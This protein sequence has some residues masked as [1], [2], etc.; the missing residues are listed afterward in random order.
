MF[1]KSLKMVIVTSSS[2]L[3]SYLMWHHTFKYQSKFI[4]TLKKLQKLQKM[5]E[6][7][8]PPHVINISFV[9]FVSV[10]ISLICLHAYNYDVTETKLIAHIFTF[11]LLDSNNIHRS[12]ALFA[13]HIYNFTWQ[14]Y[15]LFTCYFAL[16]YVIICLCMTT[17]LQKHATV[18]SFILK[19]RLT[20]LTS[21]NA[22]DDCFARY[23][24]IL[25]TFDNINSLLSFT[26]F[27]QC[28]FNISGMFWVTYRIRKG[29]C[30]ISFMDILLLII[31][32]ILF[33]ATV[34]SASNVHEAD[35]K[36][37]KSNFNVLRLLGDINMKQNIEI[38]SHVCHFPPFTLTGWN[39]FE[40]T[41]SFYLTALGCFV[42]YSLL[43][44]NL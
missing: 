11:T 4:K 28:C 30:K 20:I 2:F 7:L 26:I 38:I 44:I 31:N 32:F 35:K 41:R 21:N 10:C 13:Y 3:L 40:F 19:R 24:L 8:P 15:F 9:F 12:A 5:L 39:F 17:V 27:L 37:K 36:A 43:I 16:F 23:N 18:N 34:F 42:T 14:Y 22:I 1:N 33:T 6:I 25:E 29:P